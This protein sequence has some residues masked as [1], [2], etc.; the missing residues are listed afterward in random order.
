MKGSG[1]MQMFFKNEDLREKTNADTKH[2]QK[3]NIGLRASVTRDV[4][5]CLFLSSNK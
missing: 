5:K 1:Q 2:E 4:P 3:K